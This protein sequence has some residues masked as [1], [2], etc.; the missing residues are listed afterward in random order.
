MG[1]AVRF[2]SSLVHVGINTI[3]IKSLDSCLRRNDGR[4]ELLCHS[5]MF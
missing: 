5:G 4:F 3:A 2:F 1:F